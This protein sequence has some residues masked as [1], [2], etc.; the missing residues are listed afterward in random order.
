MVQQSVNT[1][2]LL[3]GEVNEALGDANIGCDPPGA[4]RRGK[5]M[6][7]AQLVADYESPQ[8]TLVDV[9][10]YA[11]GFDDL[12]NQLNRIKRSRGRTRARSA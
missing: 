6:L 7:A 5:R 10:L 1:Q 9:V 4:L 11:R 8:P 12:I 3:L 2:E